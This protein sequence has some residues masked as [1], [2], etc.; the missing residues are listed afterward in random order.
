MPI[1]QMRKL[2]FREMIWLMF[3]G[4]GDVGQRI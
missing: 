3:T 1:L 4:V 2:R